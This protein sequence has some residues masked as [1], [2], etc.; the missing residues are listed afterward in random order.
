MN[1]DEEEFIG[2]PADEVPKRDPTD[3]DCMAKK[4]DD[5]VFMGYCRSWPGRGTD[6]VGEGRC[7]HHF[8]NAPSGPDNGNYKH[9]AFSK[10]FRESLTEGEVEALE[11][12]RD[13]IRDEEDAPEIIAEVASELLLKYRRSGDVSF[14]REYRQLLSEFNIV[15]STDSV[16]VGGQLN[17]SGEVG[18]NF[19]VNIT[20]HRVTEEDTGE[21][22]G[23]E[24][25]DESG[26]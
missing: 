15:D 16:E 23:Q 26:D 17:H 3:S 18:G 10:K 25:D 19:S 21:G 9:G 5:G 14:V 8:G 1:V 7:K 12:H 6:H 13:R 2:K 4:T 11:E 24:E 20:H 22:S